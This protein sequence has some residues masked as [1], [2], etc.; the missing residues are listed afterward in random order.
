[1]VN[2]KLHNIITTKAIPMKI[3]NA[4]NESVTLSG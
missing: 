1:M 2:Q 4:M 3:S